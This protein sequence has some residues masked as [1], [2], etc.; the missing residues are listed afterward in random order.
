MKC[1]LCSL[2]VPDADDLRQYKDPITSVV[3]EDEWHF[4]VSCPVKLNHDLRSRLPEET[5]SRLLQGAAG[6]DIKE[7]FKTAKD[8][9]PLAIYLTN[10]FKRRKLANK[11]N[12]K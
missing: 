4:L 1:D 6:C 12:C 9:R 10:A 8:S 3:I 7:L 2:H 5:F 11:K